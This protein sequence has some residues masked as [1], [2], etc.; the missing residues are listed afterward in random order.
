VNLAELYDDVARAH[1]PELSF[2]VEWLDRRGLP[3]AIHTRVIYLIET[4]ELVAHGRDGR[5]EVLATFPLE[6]C[7]RC[8]GA[9]CVL[10][11]ESGWSTALVEETLEGWERHAAAP[12]GFD[13]LRRRTR[14]FRA[15]LEAVA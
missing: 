3:D 10:C 13:W 2:G 7:R 11:L 15:G 8:R 5:V 4:G 14:P 6:R 9:E 1:S 12:F